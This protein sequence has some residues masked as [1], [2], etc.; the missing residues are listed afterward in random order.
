MFEFFKQGSGET[1]CHDVCILLRT[2]HLND[3]QFPKGNLL[4]DKMDVEFNVLSSPVMHWV[5]REIYSGDVVTVDNGGLGH[6]DE[7][8]S[9]QVPKPT[10]LSCSVGDTTVLS[11]CT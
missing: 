7:E 5:L 11:F 4:T 6:V 3:S 2:G 1:F 10:G 8:L 9:Q